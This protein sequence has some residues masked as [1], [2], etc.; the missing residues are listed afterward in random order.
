MSAN[1]KQPS[2][3]DLK[4]YRLKVEQECESIEAHAATMSDPFERELWLEHAY[5]MLDSLSLD[6]TK[7]ATCITCGSA[8]HYVQDCDQHGAWLC[9]PPEY[10][11]KNGIEL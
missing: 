8:K 3:P 2:E 1:P 7:E 10:S 4:A 11:T 9:D 6:D 5:D